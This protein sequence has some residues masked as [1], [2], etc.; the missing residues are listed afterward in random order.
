MVE[1]IGQ[2]LTCC[3]FAM[4]MPCYGVGLFLLPK[5]RTQSFLCY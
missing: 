2:L 3:D 5:F 1:V 4:H